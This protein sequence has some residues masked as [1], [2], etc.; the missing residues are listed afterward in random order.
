[1]RVAGGAMK[2]FIHSYAKISPNAQV[3]GVETGKRRR[4]I[5]VVTER[6]FLLY[7]VEF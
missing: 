2:E 7:H 4:I 1:M 5:F 6:T 3:E